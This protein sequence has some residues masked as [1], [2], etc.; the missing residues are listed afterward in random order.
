[1]KHPV[2][3]YKGVIMTGLLEDSAEGKRGYICGEK[4]KN[5]VGC[6]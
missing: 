3:F 4:I 2:S 1:M 5:P 6:V